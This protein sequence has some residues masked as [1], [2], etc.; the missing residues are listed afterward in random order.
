LPIFLP[1]GK[2]AWPKLLGKA[3]EN[4]ICG[5]CLI[6]SGNMERILLAFE[7]E[8]EQ[9]SSVLILSYVVES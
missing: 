2:Y 7:D 4:Q 5:Y 8:H 3:I 1:K 6:K 9:E